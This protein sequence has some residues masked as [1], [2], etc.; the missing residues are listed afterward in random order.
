MCATFLWMSAHRNEEHIY[1][2]MRLRRNCQSDSLQWECLQCKVR[3][4]HFDLKIS[5]TNHFIEV[6]FH[7]RLNIRHL[8]KGEILIS[9]WMYMVS[10]FKTY[11]C[12]ILRPLFRVWILLCMTQ[13]IYRRQFFVTF[14]R[15]NRGKSLGIVTY[16]V[17]QSL[18]RSIKVD[19]MKR[20]V[21]HNSISIVAR[22]KNKVQEIRIKH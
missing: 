6:E 12:I 16:L 15:K 22:D 11:T 9:H 7:F 13:R 10:D 17:L 19:Y 3:N 18:L 21:K 1:R 2:P 20:T 4:V 8:R 5:R 14:S